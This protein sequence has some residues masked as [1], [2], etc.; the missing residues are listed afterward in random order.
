LVE[1]KH[2]LSEMEAEP[3][4]GLGVA[5]EELGRLAPHHAIEG[6]HAL[7]AIEQQLHHTSG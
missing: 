1:G 6:G 5:I 3:G 7:L 2:F 4:E